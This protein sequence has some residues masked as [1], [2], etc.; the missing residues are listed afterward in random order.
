MST[1]PLPQLP[2]VD[3][4]G[5]TERELVTLIGASDAIEAKNHAQRL[6]MI[7]RLAR[8]RCWVDDLA[9]ADG[10]GGPGVDARALADPVL[11]GVREDFVPELALSCR[12]SEVQARELLREALLATTVLAPTWVALDAGRI[13]PR[14]LRACVEL[15]GDAPERIAAEVQRRVLPR[16]DGMPATVFRERLRYHLYRL[17]ADARERRRREA[18]KRADVRVWPKDE[19]VSTL[20]IDA[21][22][23]RALAMRGAIEEYARWLRADGDTR[24]MGVLRCEAAWALI[25]RPWDTSRPPVTALLTIHAALPALLPDGDP[26]Q[27]QQPAEVDGQ[28]VSAAQCRELLA[29]LGALNLGDL[30]VGGG[31][32]IAIHDP[33]TGELL[34]VATRADLQRGAGRRRTRRRDRARGPESLAGT[35]L[36]RPADTPAYSP[37]APQKR[38]V[39][40]RD[41]HCRMPGCRRRP[42]RCDIDHGRAYRDGGPTACRNLCCLCRRHHRIKTFARGW[43]FELLPDGRLIVRTPAG[44][45]RTTVPPGWCF[46]AEP[47]PPWLEELAPPEPMLT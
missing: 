34:T 17:D 13:G 39:K 4:D 47:D 11:A 25:M 15:L 40:V 3:A 8:R 20:G 46:D 30:P 10:C 5:F 7:A 37:T 43:H 38:L 42:G 23:P 36:S 28:V 31:I 19:G 21:P 2:D 32:Q 18:E 45:Y 9:T 33:A 24:P 22:A 35:G 26:G 14:H 29:E 27:T 41:R 44:V 16:A 6:L 1:E 12:C